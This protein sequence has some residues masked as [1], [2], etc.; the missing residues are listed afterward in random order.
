[1]FYNL[2]HK[3]GIHLYSKTILQD[4]FYFKIICKDPVPDK[5]IFCVCYFFDFFAIIFL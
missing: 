2:Y 4:I 3:S 1:M 5:Y